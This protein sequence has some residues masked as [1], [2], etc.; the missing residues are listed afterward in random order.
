MPQAIPL[1]RIE[2]RSDGIDCPT[3][4]SGAAALVS[5][6]TSTNMQRFPV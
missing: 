5:F 4:N 3:P 1:S 2:A 6:V